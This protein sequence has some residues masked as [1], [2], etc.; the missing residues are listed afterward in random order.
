LAVM[1]KNAPAFTVA[2]LATIMQSRPSTRPIPATQPAD[3]APP[4]S[5][6]IPLAA[7]SP[8]SKNSP[9]SPPPQKLRHH[10]R[11]E[12][13]LYLQLHR[14]LHQPGP[15]ATQPA[16]AQSTSP[17]HAEPRRPFCH[18]PRESA[19]PAREP[20]PPAPAPPPRSPGPSP[21]PHPTCSQSGSRLPSEHENPSAQ[22][23]A[24]PRVGENRIRCRHGKNGDRKRDGGERSKQSEILPRGTAQGKPRVA[25]T[26]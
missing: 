7:Q 15:P 21:T 24:V 26:I 1:G 14:H 25:P 11:S 22:R 10:E 8:S 4:H 20:P 18:H 6:Y 12:G 16:P 19:P 23:L 5:S 3:G 17:S 9:A 2:S 13:P